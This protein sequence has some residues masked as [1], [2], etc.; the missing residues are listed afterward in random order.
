MNEAVLSAVEEHALTPEAIEQMIQL[1]ERDDAREHQAALERESK[2]IEKRI[3]RV[4]AAIEMG[5]P[6]VSLLAKL[7]ELE[8]RRAGLRLGLASPAGFEPAL[9]A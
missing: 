8:A 7:R 9:P 1:T 2:D 5:E 4:S 6:P 3:T